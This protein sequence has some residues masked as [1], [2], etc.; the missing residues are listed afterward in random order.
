VDTGVEI[1]VCDEHLEDA[2]KIYPLI[3]T[4]ATVSAR[5][6]PNLKSGATTLASCLSLAIPTYHNPVI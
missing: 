1:N 6:C 5:Q 2:Q 4:G 3:L